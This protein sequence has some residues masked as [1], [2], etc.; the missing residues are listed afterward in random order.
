MRVLASGL[1]L[2]TATVALGGGGS[3]CVPYDYN[4][5]SQ[6]GGLCATGTAQS[7]I[8][9]A[10]TTQKSLELL[11]FHYSRLTAGVQNTSNNIQ[12]NL[13]STTNQY[14]L[15]AGR[16]RYPLLQFHF[17]FPSEHTVSGTAYAG[18]LHLV[19]NDPGTG[20][21]TVVAVFIET[22][23]TDNDGL[24][25][26][27]TAASGLAC[28]SPQAAAAID[29]SLLLPDST[30]GYLTYNGSLTTPDCTGPVRWIILGNTITASQA[31]IDALKILPDN[32]RDP[33]PLNGRTVYVQNYNPKVTK[34]KN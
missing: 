24:A 22:S 3:S 23:G 5:Q 20:N 31:Q 4:G 27:I 10:T 19:H 15:V 18:E 14:L 17:H 11:E 1:L 30:W 9:V 25:P 13:P 28:T 21:P 34:P 7:P 29:A 12:V 33:Q 8:A 2:L 6:W 16:T 32:A 26:I